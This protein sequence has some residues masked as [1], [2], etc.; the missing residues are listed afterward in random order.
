MKSQRLTSTG[1]TLLLL[2]CVMGTFS[3]VPAA[4]IADAAKNKDAAGVQALLKQ[5]ADVNAAQPDGT[6]ALHWAAHWN[7]LDTVN[8]LLRAGANAKAVNRYGASPLSEAVGSG[9]AAIV[10]ALLN[11]GADAKTLTTTDGETVLMTAA[12]AGNLEAVRI[13]VDRGA[14]VNAR[15]TYKG[16][17]ALMWAAA[18]HHTAVVKLLLE[19]GA[20]WKVR[21][22]DKETRL[23][24]LSAAS[25]VTPLARGGFPALLYTAREGDIPTAQVMLDAGVDINYGDVDNTTAL[26]VAILNKQYSLAKFLV[27][28]G[29]NPSIADA[30]GRTPLY[31]IVDIRNE[32]W[33]ALPLRKS[34]DSLP[35]IEVVKA[36]LAKKPDVNAALNKVLPGKSGMDGGDTTLGAGTTALMRAARSG[37]APAMRLLLAA[38]ADP[39]LMTREGNNALM[40]AAGIGYRDKNTTGT[41]AEALEALKVALDAGLDVNQAN[42]KGEISLHGAASRGADTIVQFLIDHGARLNEKT[43]QGLTP[44]DYALG[45]NVVIQLPVP[46]DSTVALIRKVGGVEGKDL[47]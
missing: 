28:R 21:S 8:A 23:P 41:E 40:F 25:S 47:K 30:A 15:E 18:E 16:Q 34:E 46:H 38:G 45:R 20:D 32:D 9:N 5:R 7:D 19:R 37:D 10:V 27:D 3:A 42:P 39:K 43:K 36:I 14:D 1:L 31:A 24:R 35:S 33:T 4:E 12:R 11:A 29:A 26:T 6:T 22:S 2:L 13:L 44:L 17:T